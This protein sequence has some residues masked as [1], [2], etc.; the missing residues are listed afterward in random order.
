MMR[1]IPEEIHTYKPQNETERAAK[2]E[3]LALWEQE[4][5]NLLFRPDHAHITVS[6]M[7]LNQNHDAILMAY[8]NIYQSLAWTGGHADGATDL[9]QK[10]MEEVREETGIEQLQPVS[11]TMLSLDALPVIAHVKRGKPVAAHVHYNVT[12]GFV[13][14]DRQELTVKADENSRVCWIPLDCWEEQCNEPHMIPVYHK[15]ISRLLENLKQKKHLYAELPQKLLPWYEQNARILPWRENREPYHIWLSEIMLQQ[16]RVEAVKGYYQRFLN[17]LPTIADLAEAPEDQLLKLWEGLGYYSRV[18]NMQKAAKQITEQYGGVFPSD[19]AAIRALPGIGDYTAGAVASICFDAP[20]PAVDGNVLRVVSR[21]T[22]DYTNVLA[23]AFK[24]QVALQLAAVYPKGERA[25]T[26]NQSLMELGATVCVPNGAPL[27][28]V[29]PLQEHCMAHTAHSWEMLPQKAP[30]KQRRIEQKTVFVLRCKDSLAVQKRPDKGL[31]ARLWQFP[32]VEGTLT[33]QQALDMAAQW[34]VHPLAV[35]KVVQGK[36][37]FSHVEWHMT[38]YYLLCDRKADG[39]VWVDDT[40]MKQE[41]ALP[42]AF[43]QFLDAER[44]E[45]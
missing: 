43:R 9:L 14:S 7:V 37:I 6:A 32:N 30:K 40:R 26:F 3:L 35:E 31:L 17:Q 45:F 16:T 38:C 21:F 44:E 18:R 24:K 28:E 39:F 13:A 29:C 12:Y 25:Y 42:T 20:T 33:T 36:H 10:A 4:G 5:E 19:Y 34:A 27:C 11:S 23:P 15:V 2:G 1:T 41:I 22:E 8:H